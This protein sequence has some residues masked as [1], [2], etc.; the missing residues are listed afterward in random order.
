MANEGGDEKGSGLEDL[1]TAVA[2]LID[3]AVGN[4]LILIAI[5]K[6]LPEKHTVLETIQGLIDEMSSRGSEFEGVVRQVTHITDLKPRKGT[7]GDAETD[8]L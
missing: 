4:D 7:D 6:T 1:R 3:K 2:R 5:L 8:Q